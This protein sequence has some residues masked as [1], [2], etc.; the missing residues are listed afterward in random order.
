MRSRS[1]MVV[2]AVLLPAA[3]PARAQYKPPDCGTY[4]NSDGHVVPRPC[5]NWKTDPQSPGATAKCRDG[6]YSFS[7]HHSGACSGHGGV[8]GFLR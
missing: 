6:T 3:L 7:Q 1:A 2:L 4:T 8:A 5:G